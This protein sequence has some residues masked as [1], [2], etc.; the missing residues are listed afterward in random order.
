MNV[1]LNDKEV[2]LLIGLLDTT[3]GDA[4]Q[5]LFSALVEYAK[6]ANPDIIEIAKLTTPKF[7]SAE[8]FINED[9][10]Y[11]EAVMDWNIKEG[12]IKL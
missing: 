4:F 12:I 5:P 6:E 8:Y 7:K 11:D 1:K 9:D 2:A 3:T 10:I